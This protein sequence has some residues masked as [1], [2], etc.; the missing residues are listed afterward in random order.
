MAQTSARPT[1]TRSRN[2]VDPDSV[3]D[4]M[5][6]AAKVAQDTVTETAGKALETGEAALAHGKENLSRL[7]TEFDSTVRKNPTM[8]VLGAVGVGVIIGL[9]LSR[10]S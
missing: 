10:R 1:S 5:K 8:A 2:G 7:Q 4:K 6:E 3:T 9:A